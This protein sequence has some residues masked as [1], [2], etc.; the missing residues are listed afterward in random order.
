MS[1]LAV[2]AAELQ[3]KVINWLP[4]G[5]AVSVSPVLPQA[6]ARSD[7]VEHLLQATEL[8]RN[9]YLTGRH[10]LREALQ[11]IGVAAGT[12][13]PDT[14]GVPQLPDSTL[15]SISHS[16]GLCVAV[17]GLTED[18]DFLAVDL[19][20]TNR[21][22]AAAMARVLHP[23][24]VD[25]C[26]GDQFKG[27]LLFSMKEA[28]YKAQFPR[29]RSVGNFQDMAI[30]VDESNLSASATYLASTFPSGLCDSVKAFSFRYDI[31]SDYVVTVCWRQL[32]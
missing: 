25:W 11:Q 32:V 7:D 20:K 22:S 18:F 26:G 2:V 17:A 23:D 1:E 30:R 3:K 13:A 29:W 9:E 5:G 15:G 8:R 28:F 4:Q 12:L 31:V 21:L 10:C 16:R 24:E 27:S 6:N 19:E 14:D